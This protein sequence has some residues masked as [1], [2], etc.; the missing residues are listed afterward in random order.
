MSDCK[1]WLRAAVA[2]VAAAA[3]IVFYLLA[4]R[5]T[6]FMPR[7]PFKMITGLDCPGCGSQRALHDL[8]AGHPA[9]AAAHN[10]ILIPAL[11]YLLICLLHWLKPEAQRTARVYAIITSPTALACAVILM[12]AWGIIRNICGI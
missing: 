10:L 5:V 6:G 11:I 1:I 8:L 9:D 12:V 3:L 2:L 7:C 4:V